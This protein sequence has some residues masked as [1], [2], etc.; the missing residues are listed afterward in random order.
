MQ[1]FNFLLDLGFLLVLM[2]Y[3]CRFAYLRSKRE[4]L[5]RK[6]KGNEQERAA[7]N[8]FLRSRN[9]VIALG[10]LSLLIVKTWVD[11]RSVIEAQGEFAVD[12]LLFIS[13]FGTLIFIIGLTAIYYVFKKKGLIKP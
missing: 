10:V 12:R 3:F 7:I 4:S 6:Y 2:F 13:A 5:M 9:L 8:K 11:V 1:N